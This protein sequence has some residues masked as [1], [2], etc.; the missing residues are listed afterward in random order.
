M[1]KDG[2]TKCR[3]CNRDFS[4]S[5]NLKRHQKNSHVC[6]N[7]I[8]NMTYKND[9]HQIGV[10]LE[11]VSIYTKD[12]TPFIN[13]L[14]ISSEKLINQIIPK[15]D[16]SCKYC[17]RE[18]ST[19]SSLNK[20]QKSSKICDRWKQHD[21]LENTI[22]L[23]SEIEYTSS[24]IT[25]QNLLGFP[26]NN[27]ESLVT[28]F[29]RNRYKI[30]DKLFLIDKLLEPYLEDIQCVVDISPSTKHTNP[31]IL[32]YTIPDAS[33]TGSDSNVSRLA[34]M[35]AGC[36][37]IS[38]KISEGKKVAVFCTT[39]FQRSIPFLVWYLWKYTN[40]LIEWRND[41]SFFKNIE[42]IHDTYNTSHFKDVVLY[43]DRCI[44]IKCRLFNDTVPDDSLANWIAKL[45]RDSGRECDY[46]DF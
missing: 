18:F 4:T 34:G 23:A 3:A 33:K 11:P 45:F 37:W 42:Y 8:D 24:M 46:G 22:R 26:P 25:H 7:W 39:G 10:T 21:I 41:T 38:S 2:S 29:K 17:G 6:V 40:Q 13:A 12:F 28:T 31:N 15:S 27:H 20:H 32:Y 9:I 36:E 1:S 35:E 16:T 44:S 19:I 5:G 43:L 14:D 30:L